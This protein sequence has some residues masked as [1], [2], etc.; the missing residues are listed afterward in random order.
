MKLL[1]VFVLICTIISCSL[2]RTREHFNHYLDGNIGAEYSK[3]I[4]HI[5][6]KTEILPNGNIA[7]YENMKFSGI[8]RVN[9]NLY[10]EVD[11]KTNIIVGY[12]I[13]DRNPDKNCKLFGE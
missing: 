2:N 4:N 8:D 7:Y 5:I 10:F 13:T 3:N 6:I 9:C 1:L 12:K 11:K